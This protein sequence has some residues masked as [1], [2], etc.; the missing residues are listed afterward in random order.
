MKY[1]R[2]HWCIVLST[3]LYLGGC[4]ARKEL[5]PRHLPDIIKDGDIIHTASGKKV[6]PT[7]LDKFLAFPDILYVGES[8]IN[9]ESHKIQF[10]LLKAFHSKHGSNTVIGMEM[11]KRPYQSVLD[12]WV[13]GRM[14][15]RTFLKKTNWNSEWG[16][17]FRLYRDLW[18]FAR[19]K[20]IPIIALNA[21][22]DWVKE[23]SSKGLSGLSPEKK[24][25]LP[26]IDQSDPYHRLYLQKIFSRHSQDKKRFE[27]F[28]QVQCF[29]EDFMA[30]SIS[31]YLTGPAGQ[32]KKMIVFI[33]N[34]HIIY[35]FGVPKRAFGRTQLPYLSAYTYDREDRP[36]DFDPVLLTDIPLEPADFLMLVP[37]KRLEAKHGILGVSLEMTPDE[38]VRIRKVHD[39]SPGAKAGLQKDDTVIGMDGEEISEIF[40]II[41][42]LKLKKNNDSFHFSIL[43]DN[44]SLDIPV[45]LFPWTYHLPH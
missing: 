38:K 41:Y 24:K 16:F 9:V 4:A 13:A 10:E 18:N 29:W 30:D 5:I 19:D 33:G 28:Y 27:K 44:T 22:G 8:H 14:D 37:L 26:E 15:E 1:K 34:G 11:F 43:R 3:I 32:G 20:K 17:D 36:K 21:T 31:K 12:D 2:N 7:V 42:A 45:K 6:S 23:I 40:D 25:D 39:G 35:D